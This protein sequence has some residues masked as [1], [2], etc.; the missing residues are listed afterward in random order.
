MSITLLL[1]QK[2]QNADYARMIQNN[3]AS[4]RLAA[5]ET[6]ISLAWADRAAQARASMRAVWLKRRICFLL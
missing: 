6:V 1:Q 3:I 4:F 2:I 5:A